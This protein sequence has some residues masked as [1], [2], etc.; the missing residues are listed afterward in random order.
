MGSKICMN[1]SCQTAT[2]HEWKRGWPLRSGG[3]ALLCYN[4]GSAYEDSLFCDTFHSEEPGWRECNICSKHLHCGCIASK[5]LLELMDYGGV[6][7]ASCARSW[8][9]HLVVSIMALKTL[10]VLVI[11]PEMVSGLL[12]VPLYNLMQSDENPNGF[13]F[14]ARNNAGDSE[15]IPVENTV[16]G[17]NNNEGGLAQLCRLL[18][19]NEPWSIASLQES[20]H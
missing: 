2:T 12:P 1:A 16:A 3:H 10:V 18:E 13:S 15:S 7:C 9:L 5:F 19:A 11:L 17:N 4:C 14:L 8:R 20:Q 6:G